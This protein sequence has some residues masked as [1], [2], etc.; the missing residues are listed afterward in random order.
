MIKQFKRICS[1]LLCFTVMVCMIAAEPA[2]AAQNTNNKNTDNNCISVEKRDNGLY[3][4]DGDDA[5]DAEVD[6][7]VSVENL[8]NISEDQKYY[9]ET[10]S[11][12]YVVLTLLVEDG[13]DIW[14]ACQNALNTAEMGA[15]ESQPYKVVIPAGSYTLKTSLSIYSNTWLVA[16][17][18]ELTMA[19]GGRMIRNGTDKDGAVE[20][21]SGYGPMKN[22]TIQGGTWDGNAEAA[23][24][25]QEKDWKSRT[26]SNMRFGHMKNLKIKDAVVKN[27]L[28]AHH[29]EM[30]GVDGAEISGCSFN[31]YTRNGSLSPYEAIQIDTITEA[32]FINF[33][34]YDK[35]MSRNI[36]IK[37][38]KFSDLDR[39]V[40]SHGAF[41]GKYY[42]NIKICNNTFSDIESYA[43][44]CFNYQNSVVSGN[45]IYNSTGGISS[46]GI[47]HKQN[48]SVL[49]HN[50]DIKVKGTGIALASSKGIEI[51]NNSVQA[52]KGADVY[53]TSHSSISSLKQNKL[54]KTNGKSFVIIEGSSSSPV[55]TTKSIKIKYMKKK[56][57]TVKAPQKKMR[58]Y[59]KV[60]GKSAGSKKSGAKNKYMTIKLKRNLNKKSKLT[61][62]VKDKRDNYYIRNEFR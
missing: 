6:D 7:Q 53:A 52:T 32:S 26:F 2:Y 13:D 4:L 23:L 37:G 30:G 58:V 19:R 38:N 1:I 46:T 55:K 33:Q 43:I 10:K 62:Y 40:G 39:G 41:N 59:T 56:S 21:W 51:Y 28:G 27:N 47:D 54:Y 35:T 11:G 60:N 15:S 48:T 24:K 22:I 14:K 34:K 45:K 36:T 8:K 9:T 49:I 29:L 18:A 44:A 12:K 50:N 5:V 3:V 20:K 17:G 61:L 57:V 16:S 25:L 42:K 31:G